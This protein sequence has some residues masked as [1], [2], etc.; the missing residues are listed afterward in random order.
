MT[1]MSA[2]TPQVMD[3]DLPVCPDSLNPKQP[4]Y[5]N[6]CFL[7]CCGKGPKVITVDE[8]KKFGNEKT[9]WIQKPD[10]R[11]IEYYTYGDLSLIH[12]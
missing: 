3:A 8:I 4:Q 11:V 6:G 1:G 9:K 7:E 5:G 12:I 10:G 2:P